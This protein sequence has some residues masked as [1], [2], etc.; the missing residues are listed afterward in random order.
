MLTVI[1]GLTGAVTR[2]ESAFDGVAVARA[3]RQGGL[4][5]G[6]QGRD[7]FR[8]EHGGLN[9]HRRGPTR[10]ERRVG[11]DGSFDVDPLGDV[12][13]GICRGARGRTNGLEGQ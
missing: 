10:H 6:E 3:R 1:D 13:D 12:T 4:E 5:V 11:L 7:L 8:V 9:Q 2:R